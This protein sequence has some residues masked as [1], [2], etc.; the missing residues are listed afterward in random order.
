M[1]C[2]SDILLAWCSMVHG[3]AVRVLCKKHTVGECLK[4]HLCL[5][6]CIKLHG[7]YG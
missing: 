4:W 3:V 5:C 1:G 6:V 7:F 2:Q